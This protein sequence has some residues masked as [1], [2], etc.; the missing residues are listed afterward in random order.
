[1]FFCIKIRKNLSNL[2]TETDTKLYRFYKDTKPRRL[3][4]ISWTWIRFCKIFERCN[5][6]D[7]EI[8]TV[9]ST[10]RVYWEKQRRGG[11]IAVIS[12]SFVD[13]SAG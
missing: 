7:L 2:P 9:L 13:S 5:V 6:D 12:E 10:A 4:S 11:G 8:L 1:M 3:L